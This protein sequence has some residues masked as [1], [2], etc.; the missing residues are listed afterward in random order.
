MQSWNANALV[1]F[2]LITETTL[3]DGL[4]PRLDNPSLYATAASR[5]VTRT[6]H[7]LTCLQLY[8]LLLTDALLNY[9]IIT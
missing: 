2:I 3:Q 8:I 1:W 4:G 6:H 5:R 9:L 7:P